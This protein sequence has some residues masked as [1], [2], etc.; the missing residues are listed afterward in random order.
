MPFNTPVNWLFNDVRCYYWLFWLRNWRFS[1]SSCKGV[2]VSLSKNKDIQSRALMKMPTSFPST[3]EF[4][5]DILKQIS[6]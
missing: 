4:C 6:L 5:L 2:I 3:E 1:T